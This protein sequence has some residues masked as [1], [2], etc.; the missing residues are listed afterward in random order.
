MWDWVS[1]ISVTESDWNLISGVSQKET[2]CHGHGSLKNTR[3][4]ELFQ[5]RVKWS[6]DTPQ[7][8]SGQYIFNMKKNP[9]SKRYTSFTYFVD[10]LHATYN[11]VENYPHNWV[12]LL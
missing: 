9:G 10:V 12:N 8:W 6:V 5:C 4:F 11:F 7:L 1:L 3:S 2:S